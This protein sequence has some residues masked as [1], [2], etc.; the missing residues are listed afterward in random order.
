MED[1]P[2][3]V[4]YFVQKYSSRLGKRIPTVA[5]AMIRALQAYAW[6]G[7][8]REL[9]NVV[10]RGVILTQGAD[11]D[12]GGWLPTRPTSPPGRRIRTLAAQEHDHILA[13]LEATGWRVSGEGG[14]AQLLGMKATTL[15]ARMKKLGITRPKRADPNIS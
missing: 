12:L 11:L 8:I 6:P 4:R 10:E 13:T 15:E 9:E 1:I 5:P 7:N 14:A 3:L 2:L